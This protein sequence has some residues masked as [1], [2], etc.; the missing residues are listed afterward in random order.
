MKLTHSLVYQFHEW[1]MVYLG[2]FFSSPVVS[3][4]GCRNC[5][6]DCLVRDGTALGWPSRRVDSARRD[7]RRGRP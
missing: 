2:D 1:L 4:I 6:A 3:R 5:L 7:Q